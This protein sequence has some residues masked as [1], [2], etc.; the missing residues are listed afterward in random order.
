MKVRLPKSLI[1]NIGPA[2]LKPYGIDKDAE[3]NWRSGHEV[4]LDELSVP[5]INKLIQLVTPFKENRRARILVMDC[6]K[7]LNALEGKGNKVKCRTV[8][9]FFSLVRLAILEL[10]KHRLYLKDEGRDAWYA[11][12]VSD[13]EYHPPEKGRYFQPAYATI[14]LIWIE[15]GK[16]SKKV[17]HFNDEDCTGMMI[18]EAL[19][20]KGYILETKELEE[21]YELRKKLFYEHCTNIGKQ[22]LATGTA[23]DDVDGNDEDDDGDDWRWWRDDT[24][25]IILDKDGEPARVVIDLFFESEKK[26]SKEIEI[27]RFF[28]MK[29]K[30]GKAKDEADDGDDDGDHVEDKVDELPDPDLPVHPTLV[31]FD[32]RR[33][34]RLRV[35]VEQLTEYKY[36]PKLGDKLVLPPE[37]R[38]LVGMLLAHKGGF[39]DIISGKGGG[40]I[41]LCAGIPGTGKTL[42]AEVYAE[43]M[44][45]PLYSVQASQLG[46]NAEELENELLKVFARSARWKAILLI[47]EADVYMSPRGSDLAQNAIVG[48][49]LRV[50]EYYKGVL[51][52]TT[53]RADL[54]DDAIASRCVARIDYRVPTVENQKRIWKI[55]SD[56]AKVNI[57][58]SVINQAAKE[59]DDLTGRDIKN[60]LK[61][62]KLVSEGRNEPVTFETI[63]FVKQFK[64]TADREKKSC[65]R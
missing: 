62:A 42:T 4:K 40:S 49:F 27:D 54:V 20:K 48:V 11:S 50:L 57:S 17:L 39:S 46:I 2:K 41:I 14:D 53:N 34:L 30:V 36:D 1:D 52:L 43:V 24:K 59:F 8:Q 47:D 16:R 51:F 33:Q 63:K 19:A 25:T 21:E 60:L 26:E 3:W 13:I 29:V 56:T 15:F 10:P 35:D 38:S 5:E 28:W 23:S 58:V 6:K 64:P 18:E 61:L 37:S 65:S 9:Q 22:Y 7:W 12:Y 45:L 32:L 31:C 44:E 55:L